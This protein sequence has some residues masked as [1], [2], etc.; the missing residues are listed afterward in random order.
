MTRQKAAIRTWIG[1][2]VWPIGL[3]KTRIPPSSATMLAVSDVNAVA[4]PLRRRDEHLEAVEE[5]PPKRG[6]RARRGS[7]D[8][9]D[10]VCEHRGGLPAQGGEAVG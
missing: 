5:R 2:G 6:S 10:A 7:Y 1:G 8:I 3:C 4:L 9:E